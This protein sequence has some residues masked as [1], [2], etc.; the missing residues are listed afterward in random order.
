MQ[1]LNVSK[2]KVCTWPRT[3]QTPN[4]SAGRSSIP[5]SESVISIGQSAD[6]STLKV[7]L[8]NGGCNIVKYGDATD[9][10]V[11]LVLHV[12]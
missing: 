12:I 3:N 2:D 10:R 5:K 6:K 4:A 7:Y 1:S 11:C 9:V 8:P